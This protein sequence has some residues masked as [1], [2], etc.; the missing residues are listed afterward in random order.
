MLTIFGAI[1]VLS[2]FAG[3]I[4]MAFLRSRPASQ[5]GLPTYL[6]TGGLMALGGYLIIGSPGA[7]DQ[8]ISSRIDELRDQDPTTLNSAEQLALLEQNKLEDPES[9][10]PHF[11]IGEILVSQGRPEEAIRAYQSA[12]RR[13][14]SFSPAMQGLAD[15]LTLLS[16]GEVSGPQLRLYVELFRQNPNNLQAGFMIGRGLWQGGRQDEANMHWDTLLARLS[17][18]DERKDVLRVLIDQVRSPEARESE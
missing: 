18:E 17:D 6:V 16:E 8:P 2:G 9:P 3:L 5:T 10:E 15:T 14:A 7:P 1:L 13:D 4:G 11:F 12:L